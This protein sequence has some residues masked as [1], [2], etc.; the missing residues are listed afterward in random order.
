M[1]VG[2]ML[3]LHPLQLTIPTRDEAQEIGIDSLWTAD[4]FRSLFY[5]ESRSIGVLPV[6][7]C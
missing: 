2:I 6:R 5:S 3:P 1:K 4:H 7:R